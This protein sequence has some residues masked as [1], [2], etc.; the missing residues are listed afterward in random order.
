MKFS[1]VKPWLV[2]GVILICLLDISFSVTYYY[3]LGVVN[4]NYRPDGKYD[5]GVVL[6]AGFGRQEGL[7]TESIRRLETARSL[8]EKGVIVHIAC[9]GGYRYRKQLNGA[10]KMKQYLVNRGIQKG[11]VFADSAS[12]DT[13]SNLE[14]AIR[15]SEHNNLKNM[16]FISSYT[17]MFRLVYLV[18][19]GGLSSAPA[20][21]ASDEMMRNVS[22]LPVLWRQMH[23]EAIAWMAMAILPA[24]RYTE[25]IQTWRNW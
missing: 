11:A 21:Y 24:S 18:R 5:V 4:Q 1:P 14:Q 20:V 16:L 19:V 10:A 9:V 13:I 7:N 12:F 23:Y 2:R 15:I 25:F 17:H 3:I 8:M 6:F 22:Y